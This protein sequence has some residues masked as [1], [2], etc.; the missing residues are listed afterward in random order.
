VNGESNAE[1]VA[2]AQR[3]DCWNH[4]GV[5]GDR[6]CVELERHVHCRNCPVYSTAGRGL[7]DRQID[8]D[9]VSGA[10]ESLSRQV[11]R[12]R[13]QTESVLLFRLAEEWFAMSTELCRE[14]VDFRP[15]HRVP[16]RSERV[17]LGLI[18]IRGQL[19]LCISLTE[20]LG[21]ETETATSEAVSPIVYQRIIALDKEGECWVFP[22]DEVFGVYDLRSQDLSEPPVT[23]G[24]SASTL[25]RSLF[26][27][28]DKDVALL[29]DD[30]LFAGLRSRVL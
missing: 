18:N 21:L 27:W 12:G 23:V 3:Q 9:Y 5:A 17:F 26:H 11:D 7:L 29:D 4:I 25:T 20:F 13:R 30:A 6:T 15:I 8:A 22:A 19:Q 16:H 2:A 14:V 28:Q 24:S 1:P 10:T